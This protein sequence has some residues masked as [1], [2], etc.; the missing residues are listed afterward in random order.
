MVSSQLGRS[1]LDSAP[2][3]M[4]I[5]ECAGTIHFANHQVAML[6]RYSPA[7][8]IGQPVETLMPER[9]RE[10][11]VGHRRNY[12]ESLRLRPMGISAPPTVYRALGQLT[13]RGLVHRLESLNA[14]VACAHPRHGEGTAFAICGDCGVVEE[15]VDSD[16]S[17]ALGALAGGALAAARALASEG[18]RVLGM[19][20]RDLPGPP[21]GS[22]RLAE[23]A[24]LVFLGLQGSKDPPRAGVREAVAGCQAAGIRVSK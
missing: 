13:A 6:F 10:R 19:A 3:A 12:A 15:F 1:V 24:G 21:D 4:N 20:Y 11:H 16:V 7:E 22:E 9:F 5:I 14:F 8:T 18:L 23:P 17:A 2:D